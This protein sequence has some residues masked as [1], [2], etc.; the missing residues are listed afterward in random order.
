VGEDGAVRLFDIEASIGCGDEVGNMLRTRDVFSSKESLNSQSARGSGYGNIHNKYHTLKDSGKKLGNLKK[1]K[2]NSKGY[3][4]SKGEKSKRKYEEDDDSK[5]NCDR[6]LFELAALSPK[7]KQI[8]IKKLTNFLDRKGEFPIKYRPLIWRYLLRLPENS[9]EYSDLVR[10]GIHP[11]YENLYLKYPVEDKRMYVRLQSTCSLLAHWSPIFAEVTY[12]PQMVF[13]FILT[14]GNDELAA[15]ES[16]MTVLM[17]WGHSFHAT[18]PHPPVH[19]TGS[20]LYISMLLYFQLIVFYLFS[21]GCGILYLNFLH[22]YSVQLILSLDC[23]GIS[24][25]FYYLCGYFSLLIYLIGCSLHFTCK[26]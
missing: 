20:Y 13:P 11:A 4:E 15:F 14:Y 17:W 22:V 2:I 7:D 10:R 24:I 6:N 12:L 25:A 9:R 3:E 8:N 19:I 21:K 23:S 1:L 18:F 5:E 26:G 16:I